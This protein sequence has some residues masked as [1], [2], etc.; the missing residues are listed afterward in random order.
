[1]VQEC[2]TIIP[3]KRCLSAPQS[4]W[5][6]SVLLYTGKSVSKQQHVS[7]GTMLAKSECVWRKAKTRL[8]RHS[9]VSKHSLLFIPHHSLVPFITGKQK[10]W[11]SQKWHKEYLIFS[12]ET[13][14]GQHWA[15]CAIHSCKSQDGHNTAEGCHGSRARS[16]MEM[17]LWKE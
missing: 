6:R 11:W 4:F 1:M 16:H 7:R 2:E 12:S 5:Q 9:A 10:S 17:S 8:G 13:R 14:V 3:K 15:E